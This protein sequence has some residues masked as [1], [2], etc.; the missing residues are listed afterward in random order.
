MNLNISE[1]VDDMISRLGITVKEDADESSLDEY[2]RKEQEREARRM[3]EIPVKRLVAAGFGRREI[4]VALDE[5]KNPQW[6]EIRNKALSILTRERGGFACL[7]GTFGT[8][9]TV[10]AASIAHEFLS[11]DKK[12]SYLRAIDFFLALKAAWR[13]DTDVETESSMISRLGKVDLLIMDELQDRSAG[14]WENN[15][16]NNLVDRRYSSNLPTLILT[17][18]TDKEK[19]KSG[20][21]I[22]ASTASRLKQTGGFLNLNW[23]SYR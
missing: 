17:N 7:S 4:S 23:E 10:M 11:H 20:T 3:A 16:L 18:E 15:V 1:T 13:K 5:Q 12:V 8:G 2:L 19:L 21:I 22:P 14:E 6:M 9:K